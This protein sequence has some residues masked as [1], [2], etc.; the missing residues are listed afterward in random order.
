MWALRRN[1]EVGGQ[2]AHFE[3]CRRCGKERQQYVTSGSSSWGYL[4]M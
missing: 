1:P 3:T 2:E 4:G